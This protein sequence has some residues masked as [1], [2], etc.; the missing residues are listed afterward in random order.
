MLNLQ[1]TQALIL[2][3]I[4]ITVPTGDILTVLG[5]SGS[6][7]TTLL[8][9]IAGLQDYTGNITGFHPK[10]LGYI[11]QHNTL[12]PHLTVEENI[13]Y[14]LHVRHLKKSSTEIMND[15][16][17]AQLTTRY[18]HEISGGEIRRVM[19]ARSLVYEPTV[20]L[21]DEPF[22]ALD[23]ITRVE[24]AR[25]FKQLITQ[26]NITVIYVTHD[27]KEA[28]FMS[29]HLIILDQGKMTDNTSLLHAHF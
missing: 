1:I 6:G 27:I 25:W 13:N 26:K 7:K 16:G 17:V 12:F 2:R 14:P 10:R 18:P 28:Q 24:L 9:C 20:L 4:H 29:Q 22:A 11:E 19:L 3:D 23:A 21:C 15:C 5:K 8:R